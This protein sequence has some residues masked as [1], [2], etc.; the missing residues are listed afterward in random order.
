ML[1]FDKH[2]VHLQHLN[3]VYQEF[4]ANLS[5]E[6]LVS[7]GKVSRSVQQH[8]PV[9]SPNR[10]HGSFSRIFRARGRHIHSRVGM[11]GGTSATLAL[12]QSVS[13]PP[14]ARACPRAGVRAL[15]L[16]AST[17]PDPLSVRHLFILTTF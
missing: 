16:L 7:R 4:F 5:A 11:N 3:L 2:Y 1:V 17:T 9:S 10:L 12:K 14:H 8:F 6:C 15:R 13:R